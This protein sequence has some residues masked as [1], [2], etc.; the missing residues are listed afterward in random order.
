MSKIAIRI[1]KA[2]VVAVALKNQI[3]SVFELDYVSVFHVD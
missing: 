2:D 3:F 1:N